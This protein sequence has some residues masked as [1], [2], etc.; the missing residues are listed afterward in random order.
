MGNRTLRRQRGV[1]LPLVGLA[2]VVLLGFVGLVVDMGGLFVAKTELQSALDSCSLAAAQELDGAADAL[3][4]ARNAGMQAGNANNVG[5]QR[6]GVG[7][8]AAD[9]TFSDTLAGSYSASFAPVANAR[10]AKCTHTTAPIAAHFMPLVGAASTN[11]V[12]AVAVATRAHAQ[13]SCPIPIALRQRAGGTA[14]NYGFQVGEWVSMLYDPTKSAPSEMGWYNLDGSTSAS[15]TK[16]EMTGGFC[17][18]KTGDKLGT[19]GAKVSV[20]D[21]WNARFGIYKNNGDVTVMRPDFTGY[22]YT[23][24]NWTNM[25]PQNAYGGTPAAG[26]DLTAAN[27]K[28]KR[29]AYASYDDTG[30]SISH[31]DTKITGLNMSGGYKVLATPGAANQHQTNGENRRIV[32]VPVISTSASIIDFACMLMLQPI[33]QGKTTVQLEFLGNAGSASSPCTANGLAGGATGPLVP[34]LVQ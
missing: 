29:Q 17:G 24:T 21:Q 14:P 25:V 34:A 12:G 4:R 11:T 33:A 30:T 16:A 31:A 9:V 27:F 3:T 8:V 7:I 13:S 19:P 6:V 2:L 26:S 32:M 5:Y 1:V 28:T 20:D 23:S 22:A 15:E 10:Y 18:S